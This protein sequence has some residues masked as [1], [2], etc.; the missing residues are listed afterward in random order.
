MTG[1]EGRHR[2]A[3]GAVADPGG[4]PAGDA[5]LRLAATPTGPFTVQLVNDTWFIGVPGA[6]QRIEDARWLES[7]LA[8]NGAHGRN[9][10]DFAGDRDLEQ[11]FTTELLDA[12]HQVDD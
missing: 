5:P 3:D 11:R 12:D 1:R 4:F 8:A 2:V 7:W 9:R 6:A 10:L